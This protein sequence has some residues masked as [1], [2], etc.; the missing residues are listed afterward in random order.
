[1]R[2]VSQA[3]NILHKGDVKAVLAKLPAGQTLPHSKLK[4]MCR[5]CV[6]PPEE[7]VA[8]MQ[9]A[10]AL[11]KDMT[12]AAGNRLFP[13]PEA[14]EAVFQAQLQLARDGALSGRCIYA[15]G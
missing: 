7:L 1:M 15:R 13:D 12:D 9:F 8:R 3:Y 5:T 11:V 4:K 10:W 2:I 6:P 14:A